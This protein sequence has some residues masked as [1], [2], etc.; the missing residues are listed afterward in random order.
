MNNGNFYNNYGYQGPTPG[1]YQGAYPGMQNQ[2]KQYNQFA[3]VN[4]IEGAKA[5]PMVPDSK[6]LLMDQNEP[7][8]YMKVSNMLGQSSITAYSFH[9][10]T[11]QTAQVQASGPVPDYLVKDDLKPILDRIAKLEKGGK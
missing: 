10:I 2:S 5:F 3:Y 9:E 1:Q 11:E 4:G 8:F 6:M 7:V